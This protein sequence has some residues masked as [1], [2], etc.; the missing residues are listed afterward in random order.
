M[1]RHIKSENQSVPLS[2]EDVLASQN[3]ALT[4]LNHFAVELAMLSAEDNM[5][6]FISRRIKE[7]SGAMVTIFS[8]YNPETRTSKVSHVELGH[9]LI[10]KVVSI[11]GRQI[12]EVQS[13]VSDE[14]YN[15]ITTELVGR[16][17]TLYEMAMGAIPQK[18]ADSIQTLLGIDR[19]IGLAYVV[20]GRLYGTSV[21]AMRSGT[22]DPQKEI[23]ESLVSLVA[24]SLRRK[25]AEQALRESEEK[26]KTL[27]K[28]IPD[29]VYIIDKKSGRIEDVN[30]K[31][32]DKYGYSYSEFT[33][34]RHTDVSEEPEETAKSSENISKY[35][36]IPLRYHKRKDGTVFPIEITGSTFK[37]K[38]STK[39]IAVA[40]DITRRQKSAE[41][42][43]EKDELLQTIYD[44]NS[45][46]TFIVK[47]LGN[48][49][50][51]YEGINKT[52]E[53]LFGIS[54][55]AIAGKSPDEMEYFFGPESIKYAY[56][57]YNTCV[58]TKRIHESEFEANLTNGIND[59]L[60]T[61]ISP[62]IDEN[63]N[64]YKLIGS[65]IKITETKK[66]EKELKSK[67]IELAK[68]NEELE[69]FAYAN[70]ELSQFA[71]TA[72]H[73]LQEP[74]RTISNY[75][76]IIAED[77]PQL[78]DENSIRYFDAIENAAKRMGFLINS[79]LEFSRLGRNK[80]LVHVSI[81]TI[82]DNVL[83]DLQY[84]IT[85]A[86]ALIEVSEMP[87]LELYE[88]EIHQ[89]FQNLINNAIKFHAKGNRPV[90][91]IFSEKLEGKWRFAVQDN[92]IGIHSDHFSRIFDIFQRLHINEEV[93]EGKG[94][95]LA[96]CKKIVQLHLGEIWVTSEPGMGS[97]FNFTI[98][99]SDG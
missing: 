57:V 10:K 23:L 46:A 37:V 36:N 77:Y 65:A 92:G 99:V 94:I 62:L 76:H 42:L 69:K 44:Q 17:K 60:M 24:V 1:S 39:I 2:A 55:E 33:G 66:T 70:Q 86:N 49:K 74:V 13:L 9:L 27:F 54:N 48:G 28:L 59:W 38:G 87:E 43:K 72:S 89:L 3:L 71:Y 7:I 22:P 31:A 25:M 21:L 34:L 81:K 16:R 40:R 41:S 4:Q 82:I 79:L 50:Y 51:E 26:Y 6:A 85:S 5:E 98:P 29:I 30:D 12:Y 56:S 96:Y 90:I 47:V 52:Y 15:E 95:G 58:E 20:E 11:L 73:Q 53:A 35:A 93:Y 83:A 75:L 45:I 88:N 80:K 19:F 84:L 61:R 8:E 32:I 78:L 18:V 14:M 91:K 67:N 68:L 64:V 97:T 63:G